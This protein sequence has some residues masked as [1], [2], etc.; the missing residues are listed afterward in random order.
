MCRNGGKVF[1]FSIPQFINGIP[2]DEVKQMAN[3][4]EN[5]VEIESIDEPEVL[6]ALQEPDFKMENPEEINGKVYHMRRHFSDGQLIFWSN[7]NEEGI[8]NIRFSIEGESVSLLDPLSGKITGFPAK[9]EDG[10]AQIEFELPAAGSKLLFVH[11]NAAAASPAE[12]MAGGSGNWQKLQ[13]EETKVVA[14]EPNSLT[15]DYV[16]LTVQGKNFNDL[17]FSMAADS[18]YKLNGLDKYGRWGYNP[19]AVAVQYRTNILDMGARF[20]ENSG[21]TATYN[22]EIANGFQPEELKAVI[23][24]AHL[25]KV[26]VNG[27]SVEPIPDESWLDHSFNVFDISDEVKTGN[28]NITLSVQPMHIHAEIEPVYLVG[29]FLLEPKQKGFL[30]TKKEPLKTG[31]WHEQG[32]PFYSASVRYSK[33]LEAEA[34]KEY[35]IGLNN[36]EGT[37]AR[38]LVNDEKVGIIGWPP[39][40]FNLTPFLEDGNNRVAVE[41]VG[42]LKNLL[43]PHHGNIRKGIVTPWSW[44]IGPRNM[45]PGD[46]Y[47]QLDYGLLEDFDILTKRIE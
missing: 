47:H 43:G 21:F 11:D 29:D 35:K 17:Y 36:W 32:M 25:Y 20:D 42:S 39:Y 7:F 28:N 3:E 37:V 19:W 27:K 6:Q 12:N 31:S 13:I 9:V 34:G 26:T 5:W 45:P 41:V 30:L 46:E 40:E 38:I 4:N 2:S 16:D 33:E 22:F 8:E 24:W 14:S 44:F 23:E 18:A 1:S 15:I 10:L